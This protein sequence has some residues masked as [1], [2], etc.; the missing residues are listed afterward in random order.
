LCLYPTPVGNPGYVRILIE[1]EEPGLLWV[2][3]PYDIVG[4]TSLGAIVAIPGRPSKP[5]GEVWGCS[6]DARW[7]D[8][9][10]FSNGIRRFAEGKSSAFSVRTNANI[11]WLG[12]DYFK[13]VTVRSGFAQRLNPTIPQL[14]S[15]VFAQLSGCAGIWN[16]LQKEGEGYAP[17]IEAVLNLMI[18]NGM[19]RVGRN[20]TIQGDIIHW[21]NGR[22][23]WWR[24]FMPQVSEPFG[25]GG[26]AYN[27]SKEEQK[28]FYKV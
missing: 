5:A 25:W 11:S 8:T 4:R 16:R 2:D 15:T 9:K 21:H 7:A 14:N 12:Q 23:P 28:R 3:L 19:A 17:A 24:A 18:V 13:R 27:V 20:V 26:N 22:G 10:V 1:A 6:V